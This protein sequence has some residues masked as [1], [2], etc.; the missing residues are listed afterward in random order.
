[1]TDIFGAA[2]VYS[3]LNIYIQIGYFRRHFGDG[4]GRWEVMKKTDTFEAAWVYGY[5][6]IYIQI[7]IF[8]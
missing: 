3:Y 6:N 1:M 4:G 7:A 5:L 8:K 2:W